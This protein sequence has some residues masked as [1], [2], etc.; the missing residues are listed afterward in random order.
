MERQEPASPRVRVKRLPERGRYDRD[1]IEAILDEARIGH[2]GFVVD[3]QPFVIPTIHARVGNQVFVHGSTASRT[4][5]VLREGVPVCLTATILDGLVVAR[6]VFEHSMNYRSVVVLGSARMVQDPDEKVA[7]LRA[8]VEHV[9]PGRWE[10]ARRP[11]PAELKQTEL[12]AIALDEASA[13]V[14]T[15]PPKD[16]PEDHELPIWAGEVPM[17]L[18]S[19]AP[20]PDPGLTPG[21]EVPP[22]IRRLGRG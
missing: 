8:I 7:G 11:S 4:L 10:E 20:R 16:Q 1:T 12:L 22:S 6:S 9:L 13:K 14:R 21:V 18:T 5:R 15:G 3:G 2:L 19:L 17:V